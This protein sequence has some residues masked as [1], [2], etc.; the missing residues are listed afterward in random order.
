MVIFKDNLSKSICT[1]PRDCDFE[2]FFFVLF[3]MLAR[4]D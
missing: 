4:S 1:F 3:M 2:L